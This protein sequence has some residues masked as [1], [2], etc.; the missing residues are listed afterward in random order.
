MAALHEVR[1]DTG[2]FHLLVKLLALSFLANL[3]WGKLLNADLMLLPYVVSEIQ[4][5]GKFIYKRYDY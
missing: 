5:Q 3:V 2:A 1:L 4:A